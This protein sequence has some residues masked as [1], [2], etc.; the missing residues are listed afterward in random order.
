MGKI[1]FIFPGQGAQYAGMG[2]DFYENSS[3]AKE[4]FDLAAEVTGLDIPALCFTENEQLNI[5]E[6]TQIAM[7]ATEVAILAEVKANH[8]HADICAGL[9][10]GEYAALI[11]A[12]VLTPAEG[13]RI[14]RKRGIFMQKAVPSGGAM[15]AVIGMD[16]DVIAKIC[17]QTKGMVSVANYNCPG[18]I[19][20]TG[21]EAAV[22]TAAEGLKQAGARRIIPLNVSGPFHS[23]M[24]LAAGDQ[25]AEVLENAEI[26]DIKIPYITNVTADYVTDKE[27]VKGLL[28][29]QISE[30]VRWQQSIERMLADGVDTFVEIGPGKTLN[31]FLKKIN[32]E[33]VGVSIATIEDL[34]AVREGGKLC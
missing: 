13:F 1:A 33:A 7:L 12:E 34:K 31:G 6:Y 15:S 3:A 22:V 8:I 27:Q 24:L 26:G 29:Q 30:S 25:L 17:E 23:K 20:I 10:L 4:M 19:V 28:A 14:I 32:R 9:S 18:Q 16:G 5:T 21:E 2:K 11:A